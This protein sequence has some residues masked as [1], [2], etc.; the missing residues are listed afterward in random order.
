MSIQALL[1]A[2]AAAATRLLGRGA[3]GWT[4]AAAVG[5][6]SG[7]Y[8]GSAGHAVAAPPAQPVAIPALAGSDLQTEPPAPSALAEPLPPTF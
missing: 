3:V 1:S 8:A 6:G 4:L 7:Y 2:R 5:A